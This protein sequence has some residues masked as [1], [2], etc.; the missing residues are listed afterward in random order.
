MRGSI[1]GRARRATAVCG[2]VLGLGREATHVMGDALKAAFV[3]IHRRRLLA[4]VSALL[5]LGAAAVYLS[6]V[7]TSYPI[8]DWLFWQVG[9]LWGWCALFSAACLSFGHLVLTVG[10]RV[11][12][13]PLLEKLVL[14]MAVGVVMFVLAMYGAGAGG[15]Y[16]PWF[17]VALPVLMV[18]VGSGELVCRLLGQIA[19]RKPLPSWP[20]PGPL[21]AV[22]IAG[23]AMC[24]GLLY[25]QSMTP[26]AMNYDARWYH[27]TIAQDYARAG[28]IVPF[29]AEF[30]KAFPHLSSIIHTWGWLVPGLTE[31]QRWL[32][33]MHQEFAMVLWMLAGVGAGVSW[34]VH[35]THVAGAWA[36]YFLFPAIFVYDCN[37]GGAADHFLGFF[38]IPIFLAT[39]RAGEKLT[40]R[41]CALVG[42]LSGG[43]LLTKY[44]SIYLIVAVGLWIG[45]RWFW[46]MLRQPDGASH[47][48][49]RLWQGPLALIAMGAVASS[50]HFLKNWLFYGNP[51]LPFMMDVFAGTHPLQ[52]ET[53]ALT[54][55]LLTVD[56]LMPKGTVPVRLWNAVKLAFTFSFEPHA[57]PFKIPVVGSL[58]TLLLPALLVL[59][60]PR[61][62]IGA[63]MGV[64]AL[65]TWAYTYVVDRYL[66]AFLPLL[67]A[68]TG[69]III[70]LWEL[71]WIARLGLVPLIATQ[72]VWGGDALFFSGGERMR[73]AIAL[74][75]SG[76]E[77][78]AKTR[79]DHYFAAQVAINKRLPPDAVLL[80]HNIRPSL[81]IQRTTLGDLP[82]FQGLISYRGVKSA[83]ELVALYRSLGIT[84]IMH[85]RGGWPTFTKQ[86]EAVFSVFLAR[87]ATQKFRAGEFEVIELPA[88]LPPVEHS[89]RVLSLQVSG[90]ETG[91]YPV[92]A[93]NTVDA[94][95]ERLREIQKPVLP[96]DLNSADQPLVLEN[97]DVVFVGPSANLPRQLK[98]ALS[99]TFELIQSYPGRLFVYV[100][101]SPRGP[102]AGKSGTR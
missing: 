86:E 84:H 83:R 61:I 76:H 16:E 29:F 63:M 12:A 49:S 39:V 66:L 8:E 35:R 68:V 24:V 17:A 102:D 20:R 79:F 91:V 96:L 101:K 59:K 13:I 95:P 72:L 32:L 1:V 71:G 99:R 37:P 90:Y 23:A 67:A 5:C 74:I 52:P 42:L 50:P 46:L 70:R 62:W 28:R 14:S 6:I 18:G 98:A 31:P 60:Q 44:Q 51:V 78:H 100:R 30:S 40:P 93:M 81:G 21:A 7:H 26:I 33:V 73:D 77:G 54:S 11:T 75:L 19:A 87:Y 65:T 53:A 4:T 15:L 56:S 10:F 22:A 25:L 58:F 41:A 3:L 97:V 88:E 57:I 2:S 34:M 47:P 43:A 64:A 82:G 38:A 9:A 48:R 36:F 89:Y 55:P 92:E 94:L 45:G 69:A 80:L 85:Q 27:L